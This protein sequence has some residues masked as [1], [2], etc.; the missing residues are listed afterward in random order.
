MST[1]PHTRFRLTVAIEQS[2]DM[3]VEVTE[4]AIEEATVAVAVTEDTTED[5]TAR[6]TEIGT[7]GTETSMPVDMI[8][9][10]TVDTT[11]TKETTTVTGMC[12][13]EFLKDLLLNDR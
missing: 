9:V 3:T 13:I 10:A 4:V 6:T 11:G 5:M 7:P 2:V 8:G 12:E 1:R